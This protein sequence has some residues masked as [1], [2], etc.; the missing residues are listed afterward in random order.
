[1]SEIDKRIEAYTILK[2]RADHVFENVNSGVI[3]AESGVAILA[4]IIKARLNIDIVRAERAKKIQEKSVHAC[5][6]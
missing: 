4:D 5:G 6:L 2:E 3:S 1:M